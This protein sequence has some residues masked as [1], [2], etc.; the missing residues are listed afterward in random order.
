MNNRI[1]FNVSRELKCVLSIQEKIY[2]PLPANEGRRVSRIRSTGIYWSQICH[3][4][5]HNPEPCT[6]IYINTVN[7]YPCLSENVVHM[8]N[9]E[10][11][12]YRTTEKE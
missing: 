5:N 10:N 3:E 4:H 2:L 9:T 1:M 6:H 12:I 11:Y 8:C 7:T